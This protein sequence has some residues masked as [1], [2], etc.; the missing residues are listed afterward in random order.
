[1]NKKIMTAVLIAAIAIGTAAT[2]VSA[3]WGQR[4]GGYWNNNMQAPGP[5]AQM[6]YSQAPGPRMQMMYNQLDP[7]AQEKLD[8]FFADTKDLHREIAVKQA[9]RIALIRSGNPD[10]AA[11][12]KL[13]GELFDLRTT[14]REKAEEAGVAEYLGPMGPRGGMNPGMGGPGMRGGMKGGR[15]MNNMQGNFGPRGYWN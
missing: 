2:Q 8:K 13:A 6:P 11:V 4:G 1:M 3:G 14:V 5:G 10:P 15:Y 7:A 12:G 9:E